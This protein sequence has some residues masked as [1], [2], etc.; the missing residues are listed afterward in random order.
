[1]G[2]TRLNPRQQVFCLQYVNNGYN[3]V[4]AAITAGYSESSAGAIACENLQ[5]AHIMKEIK[6]LEGN[7]ELDLRSLFNQYAHDAFQDMLEIKEKLADPLLKMVKVLPS[8]QII[9]Y[10]ALDPKVVELRASINKDIMD[11][12]GYKPVEKREVE[13]KLSFEDALAEIEGEFD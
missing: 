4:Q 5:K 3:G 8:G 9:E 11:R 7:T 10:S 2:T 13:A 6:R 12:A 1:M